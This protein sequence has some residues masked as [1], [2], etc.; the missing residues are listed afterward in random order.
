VS[1]DDDDGMD[2]D[3]DTLCPCVISKGK[4]AHNPS[5]CAGASGIGTP[6]QIDNGSGPVLQ[7]GGRGLLEDLA[8]PPGL[9]SL[10]LDGLGKWP[11]PYQCYLVGL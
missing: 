5:G 7:T 11:Q 8:G 4:V 3:D 6:L 9:F 10:S 1:G 2:D